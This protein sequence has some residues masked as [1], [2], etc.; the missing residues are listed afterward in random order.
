MKASRAGQAN[1]PSMARA[2][3]LDE[4][5]FRSIA[6]RGVNALRVV[7][8]DVLPEQATQMLVTQHDYVIQELPAGAPDE[9]LGRPA[10]AAT[11]SLP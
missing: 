3:R 2:P 6:D 11:P 10:A 8:L 4:A 5:A 7:A 9:A 1:H